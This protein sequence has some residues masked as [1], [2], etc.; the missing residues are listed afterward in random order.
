MA[1]C[2]LRPR[3][4]P[5]SSRSSPW[6]P[7]S[8]WPSLASIGSNTTSLGSAIPTP[9]GRTEL[10]FVTPRMELTSGKALNI[11]P[12]HWESTYA[13]LRDTLNLH[14][15][16]ARPDDP[17]RAVELQRA[18]ERAQEGYRL[19]EGREGIHEHL[20]GLVAA[21]VVTDRA[22]MV[23][24]LRDAGLEVTREQRIHYRPRSR[25]RR[26]VSDEGSDLRKG[27]DL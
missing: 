13:T 7:L 17:E 12:P 1:S 3:T 24:A 16:W 14:F 4:G 18:P 25:D 8:V 2:P 15:D 23:R 6:T 21:E 20:V 27:L 22:S 19:R 11:A 5:P 9:S 10:H 26:E